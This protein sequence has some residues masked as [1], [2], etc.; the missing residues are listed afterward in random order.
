MLGNWLYIAYCLH[1][2]YKALYLD[3]HHQ[4]D[5]P[6]AG[7]VDSAVYKNIHCTAHVDCLKYVMDLSDVSLIGLVEMN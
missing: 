1:L 4:A 5:H 3:R 7:P 2:V 6:A